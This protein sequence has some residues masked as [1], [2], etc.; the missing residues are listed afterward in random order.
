MALAMTFPM[1]ALAYGAVFLA[2]MFVINYG[3]NA[4]MSALAPDAPTT[5]SS[6]AAV[7]QTYG[8]GSIHQTQTEGMNI[9]YLFGKNKTSG[10]IINQF[11][12][13]NGNKETLNILLAICDHQIDS[14]TD[15]RINDQ[16]Y[17]Y[18]QDIEV[19]TDRLGTLSDTPIEGFSE[20]V[21][22]NDVGS[23]LN[24]NVPLVQETD[25][26]AVEKLVV[27]IVA[28]SGFYYTNSQGG[29]DA[30]SATFDI[31]YK[32]KT[33]PSYTFF[34]SETM[35]GATT[36]TQRESFTI[37][38]LTPGQYQVKIT[39]T[40][41]AITS[42]KGNSDIIFTSLQEI[43]KK[44]LS[45]PGL[46]KY[47]VKAL[48]TDQL[49]GSV[50][51]ISCLAERA[52]VS[53]FDYDLLTPAWVEKRATNPAW[54]CYALLVHYA[55]I[56]KD[57]LIW[58]DFSN[59]AN[60]CDQTVGAKFRF[61]VN[62]IIYTGNFWG[63][64]QRVAKLGHGAIIRRG[65]RYGLFVDKQDSKISH[66]FTMGNII[67]DSFN[68]Q[69]LPQKDRANSVEIEYTD[70]DRDYTRQVIT[71]HTNE[72]LTDNSI[73]QTAKVTI[74]AAISQDQAVREGVFIINS[75]LYMNRVVTLDAFVDSFGCT[76]GD[77]FYFQHEIINYEG[78]NTGG[79][80]INA[81]NDNGSG[82]YFV[83]LDQGIEIESGIS[84]RVMVRLVNASGQED[85][86]EK[87]VNNSPGTT[88]ELTLTIPW[89]T[90]PEDGAVFLFGTATTY[91]K[92]YRV[93]GVDRKGDFTRTIV[94]LEYVDEIY[95]ENL[96]L[97]IEEPPWEVHQQ[98][99]IHV[100]LHEFL[101]YAKNG[102]YT[103]NIQATWHNAYMQ[104]GSNWAVWL[105]DVTADTNPKK[106][107]TVSENVY[108]LT[109]DFILGNNYMVYIAV[110]GEGA[111]D[112]GDNTQIITI[113]GQLAPPA[114]V[115]N[116][117]GSWD[118]MKRQ[119]HFTWTASPEIDIHHYEIRSG[120]TWVDGTIV[121]EPTGNFCSIFITNG[122][123][124]TVTYRI[125]AIDSSSVASETESSVN[126]AIDTSDCPLT[127][128]GDLAVSSASTISNDGRDIVTMIATW[129]SVAEISADWHH[130]DVILEDIVT[131]GLSMYSTTDRQ[132][133]WEVIPNKQYG[134]SVRAVD[135]SLNK[136]SWTTQVLHT[137]VKDQVAPAV[138]TNIDA[139]GTFTNIILSWSH[140]AESDL[141]H[142]LVY[143][144]T[145]NNSGS[146]IRVGAT[147]GDFTGTLAMFSDT[148]PT[149]AT[150]YY[151]VKAVDTSGNE[152]AFSLVDSASAPGVVIGPG[153]IT[154]THIA[155]DSI[156]T[157]MLK[158][159]S[160]VASK[161]AAGEIGT[162]H[163]VVGAVTATQI[164]VEQLD[165]IAGN[166]GLISAGK[167]QNADGSTYVDLDNNLMA[168]GTKFNWDGTNLAISGSITIS[169]PSSGYSKLTD[170]PTS[171]ADINPGEFNT[172]QNSIETWFETG[173]PTTL[174]TPAIE[175]TTTALK[176]EH[177]GDLYYDNDTG[178]AYR[179][180]INTGVYSW[181]R[182][183]DSDITQAL[184]A[185][186][187]AQVTATQA[188]TSIADME[189]DNKLSPSEKT[190]WRQEWITIG[191]NY[192][193]LFL[194]ATALS[195]PITDLANAKDTLNTYLHTTAQI[196]SAPN[197][198]YT[199]IGTAL[200]DVA[201]DYYGEFVMMTNDIVNKVGS[202]SVDYT[203]EWSEQN[204]TDDADIRAT[205]LGDSTMINGGKIHVGSS[206]KIG[207]IDGVSDYVDINPEK[208]QYYKYFD[209]TIGHQP[210]KALTRMDIG[211]CGNDE[212]VPLKGYWE[213]AP[214]VF[215]TPDNMMVYDS[216][217]S[218]FSQS[219]VCPEPVPDKVSTGVYKITPQIRL[220]RSNGMGGG[221]VN[222]M[223]T[224]NFN[225]EWQQITPATGAE[226]TISEAGTLSMSVIV[227]LRGGIQRT[228]N[229][230]TSKEPIANYPAYQALGQV[231][232]QYYA[233]GTW[234]ETA[235]FQGWFHPTTPSTH[236]FNI[237][238]AS[239]ITQIRLVV[240]Q[241][242]IWL[243]SNF[244]AIVSNNLL[245]GPQ[246]LNYTPSIIS[247]TSALAD[248][249]PLA[250]GTVRYFA[251]AEE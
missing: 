74:Q 20:V 205:T 34:A 100:Q 116:F 108:T 240:Q 246:G 55:K 165:A 5:S 73:S 67:K 218:N 160:I 57:R 250:V 23:K 69:Y 2:S 58:D 51:A 183:T 68:L 228:S 237:S 217:D 156:E 41:S 78:S 44:E 95:T 12:T 170:V 59:W 124:D 198:T 196:A 247:Y 225:G 233:G 161:I 138:P 123:A 216:T 143:R 27:F 14:I 7:E 85:F 53:V 201:K 175:W 103:S 1:M 171:L 214:R 16:P 75:N 25:G 136:T 158:A 181:L 70:I 219:L 242:Q 195:I 164:S 30:Q 215:I 45:Y 28:P 147:V 90:V 13:L 167:I 38:D 112:T 149:D 163:L 130:Y 22:Q 239:Q 82:F 86:V 184:A 62:T 11:L 186:A 206:I 107:A 190:K 110:S 89:E 97:I 146:A 127:I 111:V 54:I 187:A 117:T 168:L 222:I 50:P 114:S 18:Y 173:V 31:E 84:Y 231:K 39:R 17:T 194:Q 180:R 229:V 26:N 235:L 8:W 220:E 189:A 234:N 179:Y 122:F 137:T 92:P 157:P 56:D 105:K 176:D 243:I 182:L 139:S 238:H 223:T 245:F 213:K 141:N 118:A 101:V 80:I 159:N 99:A 230:G 76:I 153:E 29:L 152:S 145:T 49:S 37:D 248:N 63:Q 125:K 3:M 4:M 126:V 212:T 204:A 119:V 210:S 61:I 202:N 71:V 169:G 208:L 203:E 131:G 132:F 87:V 251:I 209:A 227:D 47:A 64:L 109:E 21:G 10:H 96:S 52:T 162:D 207:N 19:F 185:A 128:P 46:A 24:Y 226:F 42:F 211:T 148:P 244:G 249:T 81:G 197:D 129:N 33:D 77:L 104:T 106:I 166:F 134:V 192:T 15:V 199:I 188:T 6:D 48:A 36:E 79:R 142:F 9:P 232:L 133:Q 172:I 120:S 155:E 35:S 200:T 241:S 236:Q 40:N 177:L 154:S 193:K 102:G 91:K 83:Q 140:G 43:V 94:G 135:F 121:A 224:F 60:Y 221:A 150:Y 115:L 65:T 93:T 66:L 144:N 32:L 178:F 88:D 72:F 174:N 191:E 98:R 151:W 113:Q